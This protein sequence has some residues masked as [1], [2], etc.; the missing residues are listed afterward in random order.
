MEDLYL[1]ITMTSMDVSISVPVQQVNCDIPNSPT[2]ADLKKF[3]KEV[4]I[5]YEY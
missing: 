4:G 2:F 1:Y 3:C 5:K